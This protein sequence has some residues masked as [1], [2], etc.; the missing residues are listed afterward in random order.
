MPAKGEAFVTLRVMKTPFAGTENW[1][2]STT[3]TRTQEVKQP[4]HRASRTHR[5]RIAVGGAARRIPARAAG[6]MRL[7]P[8]GRAQP[9][10]L[11]GGPRSGGAV[12]KRWPLL[13]LLARRPVGGRRPSRR[14]PSATREPRTGVRCRAAAGPSFGC[15][16]ALHLPISEN[17]PVTAPNSNN[18]DIAKSSPLAQRPAQ[19]LALGLEVERVAVA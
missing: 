3:A 18:C 12:A 10:P 1:L 9:G 14:R 17:A 16:I 7:L 6:S 4:R 13:L 19:R 15:C 5:P 8:F 11:F 2:P